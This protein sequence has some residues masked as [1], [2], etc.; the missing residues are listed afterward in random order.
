[1]KGGW[2]FRV[3]KELIKRTDKFDVECWYPEVT[4][5]KIYIRKN[6]DGILVRIF[7]SFSLNLYLK[8]IEFS[9]PLIISLYREIQRNKKIIIHIH[10]LY[11]PITYLIGFFI[12][13]KAPVVVQ[14]HGGIPARVVF[15]KTPS[16]LLRKF[17]YLLKHAVQFI[18]FRNIS[19]FFVLSKEEKN[20]FSI[21]FGQERVK[22]MPMG[23]DLRKFK[24][25]NKNEVKEKLG[26]DLN[27][28]YLLYVGRLLKS[29]GLKTLLVG[30]KY[31]LEKLPNLELILIGEGPYENEL[32]IISRVLGIEKNALFKG[33]I[34]H[35]ELPMYY[36]AADVFVFPSLSESWGMAPLE[37]LSCK[38]PVIST[39]VGC[40]PQVAKEVGGITIVP[41]QN[42]LAIKEAIIK[43]LDQ[44]DYIR[45]EIR[46]EMLKKYSWDNI[47]NE[48]IEIYTKI[49]KD[50]FQIK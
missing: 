26:L 3:A 25:L 36:N 13:K 12:G 28:T 9:L 4:F 16:H 7:P 40:I 27:K 35:E 24:P 37:A 46:L 1:M 14:S 15:S 33:Y 44:L 42:S 45:K 29:K 10:G 39:N 11:N 38:T 43:V 31:A 47:I 48:L 41:K 32:R 8:F 30:L 21:L 22:I 18:S 17:F 5:K 20:Y 50:I 2:H 6:K 19:Y 34:P 49:L 23:I